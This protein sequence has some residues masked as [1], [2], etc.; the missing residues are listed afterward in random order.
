MTSGSD[1]PSSSLS[2]LSLVELIARPNYGTEGSRID[3]VS[4]FVELKKVV[5]GDI[6]VTQYHVD[7]EHEHVKL[8]KDDK[9]RVFWK[10][11][12]EMPDIFNDPY[13]VAYD[14]E[15][16]VFTKDSLPIKQN[17]TVERLLQVQVVRAN[18]P[19]DVQ[20]TLKRSG[21]VQLIFKSRSSGGGAVSGGAPSEIEQTP[22]QV[23]DV[24]LSQGRACTLVAQSDKFCIVGNSAYE[25][26]TK[27]GVN[28]YF[29]MELWRGLFLSA[30]VCEGYRPMV[31]IDV[32]HAA[33]YRPQSV[34]QY[35]CDVLNGDR[36]PP[37]Y[38]VEQIRPNT[39]LSENELHAIGRAVKGL[40]VTITHR[41]D[42]AQY[43]VIGIAP[44]ASRQ[45][46]ALRDGR[47]ISVS[48][49]FKET[50]Y[51]LRYPR[52][53]AL[54]V[55][56]KKRSVYLPVEVCQMANKQ[57]C[58]T[59]KL[60]GTQTTLVIRQCATDAPTRLQKCM[61]MMRKANLENDEFIK[62][63]G[64]GIGQRMVEVSGRVL[65]APKLE[66]KRGGRT[67]V[68]QPMN[69]TWQMRDVQFFEGGNCANFAAIT[70]ARP[71]MLGRIDDF[72]RN[73]AKAC[74]DLGMNM[75]RKADSIVPVQEVTD[76]ESGMEHLLNEYRERNRVCRLI[77]VAL[78]DSK[79]YAEVKRVA[80]V[81]FGVMT[82]CFLHRVLN[83]VAVKHSVMTAT[84]LALKINMKMG[85]INTRLLVD[86]LVKNCLVD[87]ATLVLGVDVTHPPVGDT[88]SPS[89]AAVVGNLDLACAVYASSIRV[90]PNRRE[91]VLYLED[92][93]RER[94]KRFSDANERKP[95][96]IML[97]R[98]GVS[99]GQFRQVLR[100]ELKALRSAC[101]SLDKGYHP[102]ITFIVVQKRHHAR[103]MCRDE[104]MAVGRGRN[105]PPGTVL[106]RRITSADGFDFYLC[107]HA[108]IQGTSKPAKYQ[109]LYDDNNLNADTVQAISYY[110]CHLFGR[111]T[112]AVS[113]PA[114]VYFAH[115]ACYRA[116]HHSYTL[117][118]SEG[119]FGSRSMKAEPSD[120]EL[121]RSVTI[122]DNIR[123]SMYFA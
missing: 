2:D 82:Q 9:R 24:I 121:T 22:I 99:E 81:K 62:K 91:A 80:D 83:D 38:A 101:R 4:N 70:F 26:P 88:I 49:Y 11:V 98:D 44:D 123:S 6:F 53:P 92:Q 77:F 111:C 20:V 122:H 34:L 5:S 106:D 64:L 51:A 85:G 61:E 29:G 21:Q 113:I 1:D 94:I 78:T 114:P 100:E 7:I 74:N 57:R 120:V 115:L 66:Y 10:F 42:E 3:L 90:Q 13:G 93:Y 68:I 96:R 23:V 72:C 27:C 112:R 17:E 39:S 59:G 28:L 117:T 119:S 18:R 46:F 87:K 86:P 54:Q 95:G 33:F 103:F 71:S 58:N 79:Q 89:I 16:I 55:G 45:M 73:V 65:Q 97:F 63:F 40:R 43:R 118:G 107:S 108:G 37:N 25:V 67:T 69:G 102:G 47:E 35:I 105:I 30:R 31:N 48:D 14:G 110:L 84:N 32:S 56:S 104:R 116:R 41:K 12:K 109:V 50:Y 15:S 19:L 52:L 8:T 76:L 75:G 60:L 36:M